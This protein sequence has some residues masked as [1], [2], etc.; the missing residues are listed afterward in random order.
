MELLKFFAKFVRIDAD[1]VPTISV[2]SWIEQ[3][4]H[5]PMVRHIVYAM[6]HVDDLNRKQTTGLG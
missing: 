5:D 4:L 2:R 3:E 6:L 1:S